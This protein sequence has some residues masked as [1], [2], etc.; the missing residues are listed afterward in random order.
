[1]GEPCI[2]TGKAE[3]NEHGLLAKTNAGERKTRLDR[4]LIVRVPESH[5]DILT[6]LNRRP[7]DGVAERNFAEH[8]AANLV[9]FDQIAR[10]DLGSNNHHIQRN[11]RR[12]AAE[13][14]LE[15]RADVETCKCLS[16][17]SVCVRGRGDFLPASD[18]ELDL[19]RDGITL[20]N[21]FDHVL[22]NV[23]A[24]RGIAEDFDVARTRERRKQI[25]VATSSH[26]FVSL[27][28]WS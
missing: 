6:S 5:D 8:L 18:A 22:G 17:R 11:A 14:S 2:S 9:A 7:T 10:T 25:V 26:G 19:F 24:H 16:L 15:R 12:D 3:E 1:M 21:V 23:G 4:S 27:S 28:F 20:V 13:K